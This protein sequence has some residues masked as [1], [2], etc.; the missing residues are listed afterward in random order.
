[1]AKR[2]NP[3]ACQFARGF[4]L[5]LTYAKGHVLTTARI[6]NM[7]VSKATAKRDMKVIRG[8]VPMLLTDPPL[9]KLPHAAQRTKAL[10]A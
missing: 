8:L 1:M 6:R 3:K 5:G 10:A 4:L 7:G 9:G 2:R